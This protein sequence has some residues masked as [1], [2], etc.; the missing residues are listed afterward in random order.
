MKKKAALNTKRCHLTGNDLNTIPSMTISCIKEEVSKEFIIQYTNQFLREQKKP[1]CPF[2]REKSHF[3]KDLQNN[4]IQYKPFNTRNMTYE[5][6]ETILKSHDV[7]F[8]A[9][10]LKNIINEGDIKK[11]CIKLV[12]TFY[13]RDEINT[14]IDNN[15][16][17]L[18][19]VLCELN[20]INLIK[21]SIEDYNMKYNE[22]TLDGKTPISIAKNKKFK[23]LENYLTKLDKK[24]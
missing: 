22:I 8:A 7:F 21:I 10:N 3:K 16:T 18:I 5:D 12:G 13:L 14:D 24:K 2:C 1:H 19:H 23:Q 15:K 9:L 17:K 20:Q 6:F 11:A 4:N